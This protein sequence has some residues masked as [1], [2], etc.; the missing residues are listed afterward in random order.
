MTFVRLEYL[1]RDGWQVGH[2]GIELLYPQRY[3]DRLYEKSKFGR[4]IDLSTGEMLEPPELP[5]PSQL[6][7][8]TT[9][10][11]SLTAVCEGCGSADH[12]YQWQ[13]LI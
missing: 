12:E 6:R 2:E 4:T 10:V 5:D 13:C 8:S 9:R 7:P 1:T 11:P 3:V